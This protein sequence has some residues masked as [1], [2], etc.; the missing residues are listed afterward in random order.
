MGSRRTLTLRLILPLLSLTVS[1]LLIEIGFRLVGYRPTQP[2]VATI[3]SNKVFDP[4][5]GIRY[6]YPSYSEFRQIWPSNERRY[7][8]EK[9]QSLDYRL[10]NFGFRDED[11]SIHRSQRVRIAVLGDSFAFGMGVKR[12]DIFSEIVERELNRTSPIG[13]EYEVYNFALPG[14]GTEHENA[15][16]QQVVRHFNPDILVVWYVLN[17][18][19]HPPHNFVAWSPGTHLPTLRKH[20]LFL[21]LAVGTVERI[22]AHRATVTGITDSHRHGHQGYKSVARGLKSIAETAAAS[23]TSLFLFIHPWLFRNA[24][25]SYPFTDVHETVASLAADK[26][27]NC[28]D[29]FPYFAQEEMSAL[30]VHPVDHHPNER[31][32]RIAADAVL[33]TLH[34]RLG[35]ISSS[36][37]DLVSTQP[38][39]LEDL[40][41]RFNKGDHWYVA[42]S[43]SDEYRDPL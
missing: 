25:G 21:D 34:E 38:N 8:D 2:A 3:G 7:F 18:V 43:N 11:F 32:H 12:E 27:F 16:Y 23:D 20:W 15:L 35:Q 33:T 28:V 4:L 41:S 19:N 26:G 13:R 30:H 40:S 17:D 31:A 42:F 24:D 1:F 10:N 39:A 36:R 9:N 6:L 14:T 5:P 22:I 29:L 37:Q